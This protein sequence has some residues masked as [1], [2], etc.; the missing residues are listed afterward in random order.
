[1]KQQGFTLIEL[2]IVMA[3]ISILATLAIPSYARYTKRARFSEVILAT[4]P[5]KMAI[6]LALQEGTPLS[7]LNTG[8]DDLP[9]KP[10]PTKNLASLSVRDGTITAKGTKAAGDYSYIL[11]PDQNGSHWNTSGTCVKAGVCQS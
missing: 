10:S 9:E 7:S 4:A 11:T 1:M 8:S 6:S 2:L 3:I 5:F